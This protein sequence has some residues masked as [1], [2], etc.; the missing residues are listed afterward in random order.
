MRANKMVL[1]SKI[2]IA[3]PYF[4]QYQILQ[5][6]FTTFQRI[7]NLLLSIFGCHTNYITL[8]KST[9]LKYTYR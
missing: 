7:T 6:I 8:K 3:V 2:V 9:F 1:N 5:H 4:R